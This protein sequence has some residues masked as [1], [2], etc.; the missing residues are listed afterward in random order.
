[1]AD[2][3]NRMK[4]AFGKSSPALKLLLI[5]ALFCH[6]LF[7]LNLKF[8]FLNPF[9]HD[10]ALFR[11]V[12][13]A[14]FNAVYMAG[15][16]ARAGENLYRIPTY[17][18]GIPHTRFR[19][20]PPVAFL[21]GIP[22]SLIPNVFIASRL[23]VL[24]NEILLFINILITIK[25]CGDNR[26]LIA[27]VCLWLLYFPF[28][29]EIYMGQFSFLMASLLF[30]SAYCLSKGCRRT[31][32]AA[33]MGA[34]LLKLFPIWMLPLVWKRAGRKATIASLT[35]LFLLTV[36]YFMR[37]RD[38]ARDFFSLNMPAAAKNEMQPY[39]GNQG[40][41]HMLLHYRRI[42]PALPQRTVSALP[43]AA[44]LALFIFLTAASLKGSW[45]P[46][47]LFALGTA[48]FFI[49]S[50]DVWEHHYVLWLPFFV[51]YYIMKEKPGWAF[52]VSFIFIAMPT[53][54]IFSNL[55]TNND[56]PPAAAFLYFSIKPLGN[57]IFALALMRDLTQPPAFKDIQT[58]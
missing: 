10:M 24:I 3:L 56:L 14:D 53:P 26:R 28:A 50:P 33:W 22:M 44:G 30:W 9:S 58:Q 7:L 54:H 17:D 27:A 43:A 51:S 12:R 6:L 39:G 57:I 34:I 19:Y 31:G 21:I 36:P 45:K 29:V 42:V 5:A 18:E 48:L 55:G 25:M 52:W 20:T 23:W 11:N 46:M 13:G 15:R 41:R 32:L 1:M 8:R 4:S 40:L 47:P 16:Y 49:I 2:N 35:A 37:H 38:A